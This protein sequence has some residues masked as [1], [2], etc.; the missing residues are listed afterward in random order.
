MQSYEENKATER[1]LLAYIEQQRTNGGG[2]TPW[3]EA[4]CWRR[5]CQIS[6]AVN[7]LLA[8]MLVAIWRIG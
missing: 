4:V 6:I 7:V 3:V 8:A 1:S 2:Y 5:R